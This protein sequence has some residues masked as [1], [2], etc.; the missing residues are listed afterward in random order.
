MNTRARTLV[1]GVLYAI[2]MLSAGCVVEPREGYWDRNHHRWYH[3]H[4]WHDCHEPDA[5]CR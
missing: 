5:V 2:A 3:E 4:H 1:L